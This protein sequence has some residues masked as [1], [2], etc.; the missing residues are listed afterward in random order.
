MH[1]TARLGA[2]YKRRAVRPPPY[3]GTLPP[4]KQ[5]TVTLFGAL[6]ESEDRF[7]RAFEDNAVGQRAEGI[8]SPDVVA[9]DTGPVD[10]R[11][12]RPP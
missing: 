9:V 8:G 1:A 5:I 3:S 7:R 12:A 10:P 2:A 11:R 6:A 4:G